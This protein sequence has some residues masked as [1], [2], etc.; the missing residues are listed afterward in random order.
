M[1]VPHRVVIVGA[2]LAGARTAEALRERGYGEEIVLLGTEP[3]PPYDRPPLS[4]DYLQGKIDRDAVFLHPRTWFDQQRVELRTS[5]TVAAVDPDVHEI[6]ATGGER[7]GYDKL[8]L[9]TG[10]T[11][12]RLPVPGD[13]LAGVHYLRTLTDSQQLRH[14]LATAHRIAIIGGGWIGL[15]VAAAA[16]LANVDVTVIE[17]DRL[18][19]RGALGDDIAPAFARLHREHGVD[20]RCDT[21]VGAIT[22]DGRHATGVQLTDGTSLAA[23]AVIVGIGAD[24]NTRLAEHARL[25]VSNGV[26]VDAG[27]RT[28]HPDIFAVG[29]IARAPHPPTGVRIR[30]EHW[31]N[32]L[33][34]PATAAPAVL[35]E[36]ASYDRLPY[37]FTDQYDLGMEYTGYAPPRQECPVVVR[38]DLDK[39]EFIAF[40]L[41]PDQRVLAGMN[42]N[43]WDVADPIERLINSRAPVDTARLADPTVPLDDLA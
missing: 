41:D 34:Q 20:L 18:P 38:G 23:D 8:V 19:L 35:G 29:D 39:R 40:W 5:T 1:V 14:V 27:M 3:D 32:A 25:D 28:T 7:L 4:K 31:A 9:A 17:A 37:F 42:V 26:V 36:P 13:E 11:P 6:T 43:I 22:G 10:S 12:R 16:R 15:E 24:P 21:N 30:V 2:G 33:H